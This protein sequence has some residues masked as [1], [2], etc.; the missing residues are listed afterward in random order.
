MNRLR[1]SSIVLALLLCL[2]F[3]LSG[4]G[5]KSEEKKDEQNAAGENMS[6]LSKP[7]KDEA[8]DAYDE[9]FKAHQ[10]D[11]EGYE[12]EGMITVDKNCR[13]VMIMGYD[14]DDGNSDN[15]DSTFI[16]CNYNYKAKS[17][18]I[19]KEWH[20]KK[21]NFIPVYCSDGLITEYYWSGDDVGNIVY[22]LDNGKVNNVMKILEEDGH[23]GYIRGELI[24]DGKNVELDLYEEKDQSNTN[25]YEQE[26]KALYQ[27]LYGTDEYYKTKIDTYGFD[28]FM[29]DDDCTIMFASFGLAGYLPKEDFHYFV[30][31][32]K[33]S[34]W[35]SQA[36]YWHDYIDAMH[37]VFGDELDPAFGWV[38]W[39][40]K[41]K[42]DKAWVEN[43]DYTEKFND[44]ELKTFFYSFDEVTYGAHDEGISAL[45]C[46]KADEIIATESKSNNEKI[47]QFLKWMVEEYPAKKEEIIQKQKK[48]KEWQDAYQKTLDSASEIRGVDALLDLDDSGVPYML[49]DSGSHK[50]YHYEDGEVKLIFDD[51]GGWNFSYYEE[52][53]TIVW[54]SHSNDSSE[55]EYYIVNDADTFKKI[56]ELYQF[57]G[58]WDHKYGYMVD[59]E[60]K[61][62]FTNEVL[63]K[64]EYDKRVDKYTKGKKYSVH[65]VTYGSEK[66]YDS[67]ST[68]YT[69]YLEGCWDV[70]EEERQ[71]EEEIK[72]S[73]K[74]KKWIDAYQKTI[75]DNNTNGLHK[76]IDMDDSGIPYMLACDGG[77]YHYENGEVRKVLAVSGK[78]F[79]Y[80]RKNNIV[81]VD[82][83]ASGYE[84]TK[85][86]YDLANNFEKTSFKWNYT[87]D[88]NKYYI[89]N[90]EVSQ[91]I[92]DSSIKQYS[93]NLSESDT[94]TIALNVAPPFDFVNVAYNDYR[95]NE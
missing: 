16:V 23:R 30:R 57:G 46:A 12:V 41:M 87:E 69:R 86:Y 6:V 47:S 62:E 80:C 88:S 59:L 15:S 3:V 7:E 27:Y 49:V 73:R 35:N 33:E 67:L 60:R 37:E 76:L 28:R 40:Y 89:G 79:S 52:S 48:I 5:S 93:S 68:A 9:Y 19:I 36:E 34:E 21:D 53:N 29:L 1:K 38:C 78:E 32:L 51:I 70:S 13:P 61:D 10:N 84:T 90:E 91:D 85:V 77:L 94:I 50:L 26:M 17:V 18:E 31:L 66:E 25:D 24:Y 14:Y 4:C 8:L 56:A 82:D 75:V 20:H 43:Y 22:Q 11:Y 42:L 74:S 72:K 71:K 65:I 64:E 39:D 2:I 92:Y 45:I 83:W 58:R 44:E 81:C 95:N 63:S 54:D 55:R